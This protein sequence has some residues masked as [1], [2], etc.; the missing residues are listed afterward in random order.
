MKKNL[1]YRIFASVLFTLFAL[2]CSDNSKMLSP[3]E[4]N[5]SKNIPIIEQSYPNDRLY[6]TTHEWVKVGED[7]IAVVGITE[8]AVNAI[9]LPTTLDEYEEADAPIKKGGKVCSVSNSQQSKDVYTPVSGT[10]MG[11][12]PTVQQNPG[13]LYDYP[14]STGWIFKVTDFD[15]NDLNDLMTSAQY[16][17]YIGL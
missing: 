5:N 7:Q 14:Y 6:T 11:Y 15:P 3:V 12:N 9:G 2:S 10:L 8:Y 16:Q 1:T 4:S 17:A 13:I